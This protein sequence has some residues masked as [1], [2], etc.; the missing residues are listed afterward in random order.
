[1]RFEDNDQFYDYMVTVCPRLD[2]F[3]QFSDLLYEKVVQPLQQHNDELI[4]RATKVSMELLSLKKQEQ[5]T[6]KEAVVPA[7]SFLYILN[8]NGEHEL[9]GIYQEIRKRKIFYRIIW[10]TNNG[11]S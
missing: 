7:D 3:K 9:V 10:R 8:R 5:S 1:M 6:Y 4:Q 11:N 2:S